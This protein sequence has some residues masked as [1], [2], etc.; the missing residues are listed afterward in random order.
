MTYHQFQILFYL[1]VTRYKMTIKILKIYRIQETT[2][3]LQILI[4][5][6]CWV[7][8]T[9][10]LIV[11]SIHQVGI[12]FIKYP[13]I[14]NLNKITLIIRMMICWMIRLILKILKFSKDRNK[15]YKFRFLCKII[16]LKI[17]L[18]IYLMENSK[19]QIM[20]QDQNL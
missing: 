18:Q 1:P 6:M 13:N 20:I 5:R 3:N 7:Q 11:T 14:I 16:I 10:M 19:D 2:I 17:A 8:K 15:M 4:L 12:D 9:M